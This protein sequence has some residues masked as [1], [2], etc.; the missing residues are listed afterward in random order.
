MEVVRADGEVLFTRREGEPTA[1]PLVC[2]NAIGT[3]LRLWDELAPYLGDTYQIVRHD[4][5]GHG[6]STI[7]RPDLDLDTLA[8]DVAAIMDQGDTGP[9]IIAGCE[10]GAST[11]LALAARRPDLVMGLVLISAATR[12]DRIVDWRARIDR[13]ERDGPDAIADEVVADWLPVSFRRSS[14]ADTRLWRTMF[15]RTPSDGLRA[16]G[17]LFADAD[18]R[19]RAE[20]VRI[21]TLLVLGTETDGGWR[22]AIGELEAQIEGAEAADIN[23]AALLP[24]VAQPAPTAAAIVAFLERHGLD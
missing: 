16:T 8:D 7:E 9:G 10:L 18:V 13:A 5:R 17:T 20:A 14:P 3:D 11:A 15:A 22:R 19:A 6:L 23:D 4:T 1:R 24:H 12:V 21:P 2:V